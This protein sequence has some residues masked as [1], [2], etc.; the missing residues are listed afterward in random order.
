MV[1]DEQGICNRL[2]QARRNANMSQTDAGY[3]I[4]LKQSGYSDIE[5]GKR[6]ITV[7]EIFELANA[8]NV[9]VEWLLGL[10]DS[11]FTDNEV[12]LLEK[13]KQFIIYIRNN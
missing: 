2:Y 11:D 10:S 6:E 1:Y 3:V 12:Q 13:F 4:Q 8:F 5:L 7:R 9:S